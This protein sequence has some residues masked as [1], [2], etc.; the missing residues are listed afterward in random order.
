MMA[1]RPLSPFW[2]YRW[3][4]TNALSI[5]HRVAGVG[6]VFGLLGL[7]VW[8]IAAS[9]GP[10]SYAAFLPLFINIP[11]KILISLIV[12][13]LIYHFCNGLRHLAWDIGWGFE[14]ASARRTA[15][16]VVT[17][18]VIGAAACIYCIFAHSAGA[19]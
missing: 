18:T 10:V 1:E 14:R 7:V 9:F 12:V 4:Y 8:L 19:R 17:A 5:L 6:L 16:L 15:A 3:A 13:A 11:V 2:V